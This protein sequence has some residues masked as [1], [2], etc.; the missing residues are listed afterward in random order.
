MFHPI[1]NNIYII[2]KIIFLFYFLPFDKRYILRY[3][4]ITSFCL[5]TDIVDYQPNLHKI[6]QMGKVVANQKNIY[7][8]YLFLIFQ[9]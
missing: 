7:D 3:F 8:M 9:I 2:H 4:L 5:L 6:Y 1:L